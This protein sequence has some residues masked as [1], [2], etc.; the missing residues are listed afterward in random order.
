MSRYGINAF[1][2]EINLSPALLEAYVGDPAGCAREWAGP[3][4]DEERGA[5]ARRDYGALYGMGAHP[6]L[7]WS[8]TEAVW[9]PEISRSELVE[10]FRRAAAVHGYPDIST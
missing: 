1:M 9:V 8:F 3:L 6:Y 10:R 4:T 7:L 5:L 2:R